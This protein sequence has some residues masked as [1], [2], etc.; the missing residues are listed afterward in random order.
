MILNFWNRWRF[1]GFAK[2]PRCKRRK[3]PLSA[4]PSI[5]HLETR[6]LPS[7]V[8]SLE[9]ATPFF[10]IATPQNGA[11]PAAASGPTGY[12]PSQIAQA[13]GF[14]QISFT[15]GTSTVTGNGAGQTIAIV[16]AYNDPDIS[17]DLKAFD[18]QFGLPNPTLTVVG[19]TGGAAPTA[20]DP[21]GDWE[22]EES[23]DVEWA[24]AI[25]P[26]ANIVLVEA[27]ND[28][29]T[30]LMTAVKTA[31]NYPGVSVV[32]MS[33]GG[34]EFSGETNDDSAYFSTP[35]VPANVA[36]VAAS[37]DSGAPPIYPAVS[38][39]VLAVGGTTLDLSS[40]GTYESES[41]WSGSGGGI[42]SY[43]KLPSYQ[44]DTYSNGTSTGTST[45]RMNPDVSY[46]ANP[47][48]GFAV[49]D[50]NPV[51]GASGPWIEVG[52][53]SDAAPQWAGLVA[54]ADQGRALDG[55]SS[56]GYSQLLT[57]IYQMP[58]SNFHSITSGTSTGDPHYSASSGY[59][60][61]TGRGTPIA[62]LVVNSL[63]NGTSTS[64]P[65]SPAPPPAPPPSPA[66]PPAPPPAPSP[67]PAPPPAPSPPP[68]PPP[69][70]SPPPASG[71]LP[72]GGFEQPSVGSSYAVDPAG[73]P[74]TYFGSA[75]VA[76][77]GSILTSG[78]P[79]AP[80]GT[81]VGF[82]ND[83]YSMISQAVSLTV[84]NTYT[85]S[86]DAAQAGYDQSSYQEI[87]VF[88]DNTAVAVVRPSST[89]YAVYTSVPFYVTANGNYTITFVGLDPRG[90][91]NTAFLDQVSLS[92]T[93]SQARG[94]RSGPDASIAQAAPTPSSSTGVA[95]GSR[96][97]ASGNSQGESANSTEPAAFSFLNSLSLSD[98]LFAQAETN[99]MLELGTLL[100]SGTLSQSWLAFQQQA[101][102]GPLG[103]L[104]NQD[105][106]D[107]IM[108][109]RIS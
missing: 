102:L 16:D 36:F 57:D 44:P 20:T 6:T 91:N 63:V 70:P 43:E 72:D 66:P 35:N 99:L 103:E 15:N 12:T 40:S 2:K 5:E 54:I 109:G 81:Q 33:W 48:T 97:P 64:P 56:L 37:G 29:L 11:A 67:P 41:A 96:T 21:T 106:L 89:S 23:L 51:S 93:P 38:P 31:A 75:G 73:T 107:N 30:N 34:S 28:S 26:A 78:N 95:A 87:E 46:D 100:S 50:S 32:S 62:N 39:N 17:S 60:L 4:R 85:I 108:S 13:Y 22:L 88:V 8:A 49:Y 42:S 24:H 94:G 76:G 74:W 71:L 3:K 82:L 77:N 1:G 47:D 19:Q 84:G 105:W 45:M 79:S 58:A 18:A 80:Q 101:A 7:T 83:R 92:A 104:L 53:T 10:I 9:T 86:F 52:G 68:A 61:V 90:G 27:N 98:Q 14:N 25:A 69:S 65:P 55:E 59:N